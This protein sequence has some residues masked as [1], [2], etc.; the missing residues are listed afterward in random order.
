MSNI[1]A[2]NDQKAITPTSPNKSK[3]HKKRKHLFDPPDTEEQ[4]KKAEKKKAKNAERIK[5]VQNSLKTFSGLCVDKGIDRTNRYSCMQSL[6]SKVRS[7]N[8]KI[9][10]ED[11]LAYIILLQAILSVPS[12]YFSQFRTEIEDELAEGSICRETYEQI[13]HSESKLADIASYFSDQEPIALKLEYFKNL[14]RL[15][16]ISSYKKTADAEYQ[17]LATELIAHLKADLTEAATSE[18][19]DDCSDTDLDTHDAAEVSLNTADDTPDDTVINPDWVDLLCQRYN[20]RDEDRPFV[21][22]YVKY[23]AEHCKKHYFNDS[24]PLD[25]KLTIKQTNQNRI[26]PLVKQELS[27]ALPSYC[28]A[29][30]AQK[31]SLANYLDDGYAIEFLPF[32]I[33]SELTSKHKNSDTDTKHKSTIFT[34][35]QSNE[36]LGYYR[37]NKNTLIDKAD[38][39]KTADFLYS[40]IKHSV[41]DFLKQKRISTAKTVICEFSFT[42]FFLHNRPD[43]IY[44]FKFNSGFSTFYVSKEKTID[45]FTALFQLRESDRE[46]LV[47]KWGTYFR[48]FSKEQSPHFR[49]SSTATFT[50][51]KD[52]WKQ[53]A[54]TDAGDPITYHGHEITLGDALEALFTL[55]CPNTY[56]NQADE[57]VLLQSLYVKAELLCCL[58]PYD[59]TT[60]S[61]WKGVDAL[62]YF[63]NEFTHQVSLSD[64]LFIDTIAPALKAAHANLEA[65]SE[66]PHYKDISPRFDLWTDLW[67]QLMNQLKELHHMRKNARKWIGFPMNKKNYSK[68]LSLYYRKG[69]GEVIDRFFAPQ[70]PDREHADFYTSVPKH[71]KALNEILQDFEKFDI[72]ECDYSIN[73]FDDHFDIHECP[74]TICARADKIIEI[75]CSHA[76]WG[77]KFDEKISLLTKKQKLTIS[78]IIMEKIL[79]GLHWQFLSSAEELMNSLI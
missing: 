73:L 69:I 49:S 61:P 59:P 5:V 24:A 3:A 45:H 76:N 9:K 16:T 75:I 67:E 17:S 48:N 6:L 27:D 7:K 60:L 66:D 77:D 68:V 29:L 20:I 64:V 36:I 42:Q 18:I 12:F 23:H 34:H 31:D 44:N 38:N 72:L 13:C 46:T 39:L 58:L 32:L 71:E 8:G 65:L 40:A 54:Y 22:Y 30:D 35:L 14:L 4:R 19:C 33:F 25:T 11:R 51:D 26:D 57:S 2:H 74:E 55:L 78:Y 28:A 50:N 79:T 1:N 41:S 21:S 63:F 47:Q 10:I 52:N 15:L 62:G 70:E 37:I 56:Y 43:L 53:I